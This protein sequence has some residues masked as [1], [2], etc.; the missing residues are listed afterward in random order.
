MAIFISVSSRFLD[1]FRY[2]DPPAQAKM[3]RQ[4][5]PG[6]RQTDQAGLQSGSISASAPAA[7]SRLSRRVQ[8]PRL[9]FAGAKGD[10]S[11]MNKIARYSLSAPRS[12]RLVAGL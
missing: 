11:S 1:L 6:K 10:L 12:P 2:G 9:D 5:A 3:Q 4:P 7:I 8:A